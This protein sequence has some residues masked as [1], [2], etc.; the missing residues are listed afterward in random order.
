MEPCKSG[1]RVPSQSWQGVQIEVRG[2]KQC[3]AVRYVSRLC[4]C[5]SP[6]QDAGYISVFDA[7]QNVVFLIAS[8]FLVTF[9]CAVFN[10]RHSQHMFHV[11]AK[12]RSALQVRLIGGGKK[13]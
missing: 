12:I 3:E 13:R 5:L 6:V 8:L 9:L 7:V 11:G 10:Q 1:S 2:G 4:L